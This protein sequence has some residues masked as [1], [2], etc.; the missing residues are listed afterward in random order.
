MA[1]QTN[2]ESPETLS[3]YPRRI[4]YPESRRSGETRQ[5]DVSADQRTSLTSFPSNKVSI[6]TLAANR[7]PLGEG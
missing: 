5:S 4:Y 7:L 1:F 2:P 3:F 6:I